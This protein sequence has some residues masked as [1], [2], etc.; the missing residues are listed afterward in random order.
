MACQEPLGVT[1]D[2]F[3]ASSLDTNLP[4]VKAVLNQEI[5]WV[6]TINGQDQWLQI[7]LYHQILV[8]GVVIQGRPD[9]EE[10]VTRYR[11]E[12]ALDGVSWELVKDESTSTEVCNLSLITN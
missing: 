11:V 12:Y 1:N 9:M 6:P 5:A 10:W 7:D 3:T 2:Q 8:S 4:A